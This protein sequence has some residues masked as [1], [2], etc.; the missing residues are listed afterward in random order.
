MS[1][2][3]ALSREE[4]AK[5]L[6]ALAPE[7][8]AAFVSSFQ[9]WKSATPAVLP[10]FL[11]QRGR[12]DADGN[13][14]VETPDGPA[15]FSP[16]GTRILS[17]QELALQQEAGVARGKTDALETGLSA[18]HGAANSLTNK[19]AGAWEAIKDQPQA[20]VAGPVAA[21]TM[22]AGLPAL[23]LDAQ[24]A[25]DAYDRGQRNAAAAVDPAVARHP[26][27]NVAGALAMPMPGPSKVA[28]ATR[29][30]RALPLAAGAG[31]SGT[32]NAFGRT[33]ADQGA[34]DA[35][36][37]TIG[38]GLV[39][40]GL[41]LGL[42]AAVGKA[43]ASRELL[44]AR[45]EASSLAELETTASSARGAA[46][47]QA[48]QVGVTWEKLQQALTDPNADPVVRLAAQ[49]LAED[50]R[51]QEA[52]KRALVNRFQ[53]GGG[54]LNDLDSLRAIASEASSGIPGKAAQATEDYFTKSV[55]SQDVAPKLKALASRGAIGL[56]G[57]A[58][59]SLLG[60][61]GNRGA[62]FA[63]G[64]AAGLAAPGTL[65]AARNLANSPR[66]QD[67]AWSALS[68]SA[69]G[70]NKLQSKEP[71]FDMLRSIIGSAGSPEEKRAALAAALQG[72]AQ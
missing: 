10:G 33:T 28:G 12:R 67:R 34:A 25:R 27:A 54:D 57:G 17:P 20:L 53:R 51:M 35:A 32:L 29:L 31:T 62:G 64:L 2:F 71:I 46:G 47:A 58:V 24:R 22:G 65:Q 36:V 23:G 3:E 13:Y 30:A 41:G 18:I 49:R 55:V 7:Q 8:R 70:L 15:R 39:A 48:N 21:M 6:G 69:R 61:E 11:A 56:A 5:R 4:K 68:S 60:G 45:K 43:G 38:G 66:V 9:Q 14:T 52:A 63:G 26:L 16:D 44:R 40:G 1:A 50:P 42:G 59:G 19:V 37:N 72:G